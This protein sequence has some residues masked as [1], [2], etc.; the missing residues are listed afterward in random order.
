MTMSLFHVS[1][2]VGG[3]LLGPSTTTYFSVV[4]PSAAR[5]LEI[6]EQ[7]AG[8]PGGR[9]SVEPSTKGAPEDT[10]PRVVSQRTLQAVAA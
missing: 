4:A 2:V 3:S 9:W 8:T 1:H 7:N 10:T 6:A 5:A